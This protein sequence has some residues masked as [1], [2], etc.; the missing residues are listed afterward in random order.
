MTWLVAE[1]DRQLT[2][3]RYSE[4]NQPWHVRPIEFVVYHFTAGAFDGSLRW[5]TSVDSRVSAHFLIAKSG[6]IV[7]LAPLH[8]RT[9]HAG[10]RTSSWRG[11]RFVNDRSIG[12]EIEN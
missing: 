7:Q 1:G 6:R 10:G 11:A 3:N 8:D 5:L 9:W 2:P 4:S 12:V